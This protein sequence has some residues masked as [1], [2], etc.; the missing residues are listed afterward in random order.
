MNPDT[1]ATL[2][3]S[4]SAFV[5]TLDT[6]PTGAFIFLLILVAIFWRKDPRRRAFWRRSK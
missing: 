2:L 1:F 5:E 3:S 4:G 6:H